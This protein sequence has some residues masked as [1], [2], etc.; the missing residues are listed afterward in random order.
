MRA[1][2]A[3]GLAAGLILLAAASWLAP[4]AGEAA[5]REP[6][7]AALRVSGVVLREECALPEP[8]GPYIALLPDGARAAAG[9]AAVALSAGHEG[10]MCAA[11]DAARESPAAMGFALREAVLAAALDMPERAARL[12][13]V[14]SAPDAGYELLY[15]PADALWTSR[16]DGYEYLAP[17]LLEGLDAEGLDGLMSARPRQAGPLAGKYVTA[18]RWYFAAYVPE[19]AGV[20]EGARV[21]LDFGSFAAAAVVESA[22]E[23]AGGLAAVV[24][25]STEAPERAL[26]LRFTEAELSVGR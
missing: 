6:G 23:P 13:A 4:G 15:A 18:L 12:E 2:L 26:E 3:P 24:F 20:E 7:E 25:S 17:S 22:S 14:Y 9:E 5:A 19:G 11:R 8:E 21:R 16:T 10:L 1:G